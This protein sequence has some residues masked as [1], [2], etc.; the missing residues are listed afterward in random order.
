MK[1]IIASI[2]AVAALAGAGAASAQ[3]WRG[4]D[5]GRTRVE[6]M[7]EHGGYRAYHRHERIRAERR[8]L[9]RE[10]RHHHHH[11]AYRGY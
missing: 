1:R 3:D 4:R 2:L 10:L 11:H 8:H 6:R 9:R 7:H 5:D